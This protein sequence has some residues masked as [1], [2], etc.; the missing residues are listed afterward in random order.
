MKA[1]GK[2]SGPSLRVPPLSWMNMFANGVAVYPTYA[3]LVNAC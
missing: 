2:R 1:D 3:D